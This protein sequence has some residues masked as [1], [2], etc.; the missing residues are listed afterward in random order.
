MNGVAIAMHSGSAHK[1][2]FLAVWIIP[3]LVALILYHPTGEFGLTFDD[4]HTILKNPLMRSNGSMSQLFRQVMSTDYWG[5]DFFALTSHKSYRPLTVFSFW[6]D[7][8]RCGDP[9]SQCAAS[10]LHFSN[11]FDTEAIIY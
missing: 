9:T 4:A 1:F 7:V 11:I 8:Q 3:A 10:A 2:L 6:L 5:Q